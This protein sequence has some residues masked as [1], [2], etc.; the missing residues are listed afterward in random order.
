MTKPRNSVDMS[1]EAIAARLERVR[2]L[3]KLMVSLQ[4]I[5]VEDARP[6]AS[7]K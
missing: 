7:R 1:A 2:A 3:Y 6:V 5:R 4:D